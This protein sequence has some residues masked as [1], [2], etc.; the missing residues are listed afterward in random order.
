MDQGRT[1][2]KIFE[3]KP[4][5]SRRMGKPRLRWVEDTEKDLCEIKVK[6]WPQ[7]G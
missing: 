7:M 4:E 1:V 5:G 2:K 3:C 6:R